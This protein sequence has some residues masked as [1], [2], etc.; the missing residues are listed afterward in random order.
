MEGK[1]VACFRR[2]EFHARYAFA[3]YVAR[4]LCGFDLSFYISAG[5]SALYI[6]TQLLNL[7]VSS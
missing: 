3:L 7:S 4:L 2:P 1:N 6:S 5:V